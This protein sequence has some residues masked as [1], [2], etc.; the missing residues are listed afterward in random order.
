MTAGPAPVPDQGDQ[1]EGGDPLEPHRV[2]QALLEDEPTGGVRGPDNGG[3]HRLPGTV[4]DPQVHHHRHG[5]HRDPQQGHDDQAELDPGDREQ[6]DQQRPRSAEVDGVVGQERLAQPDEPVELR[7]DGRIPVQQVLEHG[8]EGDELGEVVVEPAGQV[9]EGVLTAHGRLHQHHRDGQQGG[10]RGRSGSA[11]EGLT[12]P[13][14]T[15]RPAAVRLTRHVAPGGSPPGR[16]D[17][18]GLPATGG[19]APRSS[20]GRSSPVRGRRGSGT[21]PGTAA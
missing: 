8:V 9:T 10:E 2:V 20:R 7:V 17:G 11:G 19:S 4:G 6:A 12:P 5:D 14:T 16:P 3:E 13:M 21:V 18:I 15:R 1:R